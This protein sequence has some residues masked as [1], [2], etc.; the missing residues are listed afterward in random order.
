ME[1]PGPRRVLN[2]ELISLP[3]TFA[4]RAGTLDPLCLARLTWQ[5]YL[6]KQPEPWGTLP[7]GAAA[8][9]FYF[10]NR[11]LPWPRLQH[12]PVDGFDNN[13]R[14]LGAHALLREML[15]AEK[16]DDAECGQLGY[17]LSCTDPVSGL[18][19]S[20]D[21]HPRQCPLAQGELARNVILLYQQTGRQDLR[22]WAAKM[23]DTLWDHAASAEWPGVGPVAFYCQGG[24]GG[25]GGFVVGEP[26]RRHTDD[27]A[28]GGWQSLY[29]GW[30]AAAFSAWYAL[31]GE[32][33]ALQRA[34]ALANRLCHSADPSGSDGSLRSDGSFGGVS[35]GLGSGL[36]PGDQRCAGSY[37]MHGHTHAL[38]G[39]V[40][41]GEQ[42]LRGGRRAAGLSFIEQAARTLDWLYDPARNPDSGS[43]TGWLPEFLE[44][45][46]ARG[47]NGSVVAGDCEGCTMGDV[48]QASA[49]L[50]A[51]SRADPGLSSLAR[52]YDRAE[53]I[54]RGQLMGQVFQLTSRYRAALR[55]CLERRVVKEFPD[56]PSG[57][58]Q[59]EVELRYRRGLAVAERMVGQQLGLCGF[60]DWANAHP[61]DL[62]PEL[63]GI[64]MQGCCA[65][66]TIRAAHA[67]W[68]QTVT[69]DADET[70]VNLAF[71]RVS[72]L[73]EVIS[74]LPHRGEV[75]VTVRAARR[76]LVR[77]PGWAPPQETRAYQNGHPV[78]VRWHGAYVVFG[79]VSEGQQLTVT[80]PLAVT[81]VC[82]V[83][84]GVTYTERWR[85]HTITD[86][87][88]SGAW[89]PL[90]QRPALDTD[91]IPDVSPHLA[92]EEMQTHA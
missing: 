14:N 67:V 28:L 49:A 45:A 69:G 15:G 17:L 87:T 46:W 11:A 91:T 27:P 56:S 47:P 32:P 62:D 65:D 81:E 54:F 12:H 26:P 72:P 9:R 1:T 70:W 53:Q 92:V 83:I 55:A 64:H 39:L 16:D 25:Q 23:L 71:N 82:E 59:G 90:F 6:R 38:A 8:L 50:G 43:L 76:V 29:V 33:Q 74:C 78:P 48:V 10:D 22:V 5:G 79:P 40:Q 34:V 18:A 7:G 41:L 13:A 35:A 19:Y 66:A 30:N 2:Q 4:S 60:G 51:A 20:P 89:V 52:F 57:V 3:P 37:H 31:T 58:R 80:Y 61:S 44:V 75:N 85:G 21:I 73:V 68:Q 86:V 77:V 84:D 42:L 88:P 36:L 63:P 24:N